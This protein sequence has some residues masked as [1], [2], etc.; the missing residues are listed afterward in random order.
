MF[1]SF[2]ETALD[3]IKWL[4]ICCVFWTVYTLHI[5]KTERWWFVAFNGLVLP[6]CKTLELFS[7]GC[8][9]WLSMWIR[10]LILFFHPNS[11]S[12]TLCLL[13][14]VPH[15]HRPMK[16]LRSMS[17][18]ARFGFWITVLFR[19]P[20]WKKTSRYLQ[21]YGTSFFDIYWIPWQYHIPSMGTLW[22]CLNA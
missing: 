5:P 2:Y 19:A 7:M 13:P 21:P 18:S 17:V 14:P 3:S 9:Y 15:R 4:W 11:I 16:L 12:L 1:F 8:H 10:H 6:M 22:K 20:S